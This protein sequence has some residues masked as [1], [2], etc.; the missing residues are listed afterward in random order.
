MLDCKHRC[1]PDLLR[2]ASAPLCVNLNGRAVAQ[3][4]D[5]K[6]P[7]R[8]H[9][10]A[11]MLSSL[12]MAPAHCGEAEALLVIRHWAIRPSPGGIL[13]Q[14]FTMSSRHAATASCRRS[15]AIW[16]FSAASCASYAHLG[17]ILS[18]YACMQ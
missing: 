12:S 9:L 1:S 5:G 2:V 13:P 6:P 3:L 17:L 7:R 18:S 10:A 16:K 8:D 4:P 14:S 15:A 11:A